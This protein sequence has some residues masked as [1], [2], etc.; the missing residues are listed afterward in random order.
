M[1][2]FIEINLFCLAVLLNLF[3]ADCNILF[4]KRSFEPLIDFVPCAGGFDKLE[5]IE[6]RS[7]GVL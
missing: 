2:D 7:L 1:V 3:F 4:F 5:P 6:T